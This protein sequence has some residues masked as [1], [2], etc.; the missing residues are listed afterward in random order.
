[1]KNPIR[2]LGALLVTG[3]LALTANSAW[4]IPFTVQIDATLLGGIGGTWELDG[5]TDLSDG[6][7][8]ALGSTYSRSYDIAPGDYEFEIGGLGIGCEDRRG[9]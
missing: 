6:W 3:W 9:G 8:A 7:F 5:P 4:A 2:V 1:M